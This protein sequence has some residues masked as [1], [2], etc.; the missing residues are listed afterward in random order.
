MTVEGVRLVVNS[1]LESSR[2]PPNWL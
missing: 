2:K 1:I